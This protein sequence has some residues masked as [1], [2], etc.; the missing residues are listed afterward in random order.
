[1]H[2]RFQMS[3]LISTMVV[4][5]SSLASQDMNKMTTSQLFVS[6]TDRG[7]KKALIRRERK[8]LG[9]ASLRSLSIA[10]GSTPIATEPFDTR[11]ERHGLMEIAA[12]G[13][14]LLIRGSSSLGNA[15]GASRASA[16]KF[17]TLA[18]FSMDSLGKLREESAQGVDT[19]MR[20]AY[21]KSAADGGA[22]SS[23][24]P[25]A[26]LTQ[27][28]SKLEGTQAQVRAEEKE[29]GGSTLPVCLVIT[30]IALISILA[31]AWRIWLSRMLHTLDLSLDDAAKRA[32]GKILQNGDSAGL[33]EV[34]QEEQLPSDSRYVELLE[35]EFRKEDVKMQLKQL[36]EALSERND[37]KHILLR[38]GWDVLCVALKGKVETSTGA[39]HLLRGASLADH[40]WLV[41]QIDAEIVNEATFCAIFKVLV[42]WRIFRTV[43]SFK[44]MDDLRNSVRSWLPCCLAQT[45]DATILSL[46]TV[47]VDIDGAGIALNMI[48]GEPS[49][50]LA[51]GQDASM[52]LTAGRM[53]V[54]Q[55]ERLPIRG[56]KS[57]VTRVGEFEGMESDRP[58][59]ESELDSTIDG[60]HSSH[61]RLPQTRK[62]LARKK[63]GSTKAIPAQSPASST[64][65]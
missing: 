65:T 29:T 49:S 53:D 19:I 51:N 45:P 62:K 56:N 55:C 47:W 18:R 16:P 63:V 6:T 41:S 25:D 5:C 28:R 11:D 27:P 8:R 14:P 17:P 34:F 23:R 48:W 61:R 20:K 36:F 33:L 42:M 7:S 24:M 43:A 3:L 1:M 13:Q 38:Q 52:A 22:V 44:A 31:I 40:K 64:D 35:V 46:F 58:E 60:V 12:I 15:S 26:N 30:A 50:M 10:S 9:H 37:R 59:V 21:D 57:S 32:V 54:D 39:E 2:F 4:L